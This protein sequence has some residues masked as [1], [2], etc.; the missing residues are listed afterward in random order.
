MIIRAFWLE[1]KSLS[2]KHDMW[3]DENWRS[4]T[5]RSWFGRALCPWFYIYITD[6]DPS[7][8]NKKRITCLMGQRRQ[9][10]SRSQNS[11][12]KENR[13]RYTI[14]ITSSSLRTSWQGIRW[15]TVQLS[16]IISSD[17]AFPFILDEY[18]LVRRETRCEKPFFSVSI[19]WKNVFRI[20]KGTCPTLRIIIGISIIYW[21]NKMQV[22]LFLT[23]LSSKLKIV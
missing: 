5:S 4:D 20:K 14:T 3:K 17:T 19:W 21:A 10:S 23:S 13:L 12:E 11:E 16:E 2:G 1:L 18:F 8:W 9:M 22:G 7:F 6:E 15:K